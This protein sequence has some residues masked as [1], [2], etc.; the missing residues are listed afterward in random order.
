MHIARKRM[1][2]RNWLLTAGAAFVLLLSGCSERKQE[3][4]SQ[5]KA[6]NGVTEVAEA[7]RSDRPAEASVLSHLAKILIH[8]AELTA[9]DLKNNPAAV[10]AAEMVFSPEEAVAKSEQSLQEE[11]QKLDDAR[12][13]GGWWTWLLAGGATAAAIASRFVPGVGPLLSGV[14]DGAAAYLGKREQYAKTKAKVAELEHTATVMAGTIQSS[15][16]GRH[17]LGKLDSVIGSDVR[18]AIGTLT[19]GKESTVEGLFTHIAKGAAVDN[20]NVSHD[21]VRR[22]LAEVTDSIPT[23]IGVPVTIQRT[24]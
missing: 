2:T 8:V 11:T 22:V 24:S 12:D 3:R 14:L 21:D 1:L 5:A 4:A 10:S 6:V 18:D 15:V 17:A 20:E 16:I 7:I 19:G 9:E 13:G 23:E